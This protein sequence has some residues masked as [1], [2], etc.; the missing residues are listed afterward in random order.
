M[1][2]YAIYYIYFWVIYR[3]LTSALLPTKK[4]RPSWPLIYRT[5]SI[6]LFRPYK[7]DFDYKSKTIRHASASLTYEGISDLNLYCPAVS[8]SWSLSVYPSTCIVLVMKSIPTVG[9]NKSI[10]YVRRLLEGVMYESRYDWGF[11]DILVAYKHDF[12][13]VYFW[14]K[15]LEFKIYNLLL[16]L[17]YEQEFV[18]SCCVN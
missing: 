4:I 1:L 14:H 6:H 11:T 13:F 12:E 16:Y 5:K 2:F 7:V 17:F 3:Y 10:F 18:K 9:F 8:Q 15:N